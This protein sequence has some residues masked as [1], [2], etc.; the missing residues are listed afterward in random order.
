MGHKIEE[1]YFKNE[2]NF[3]RDTKC[4]NSR[5]PVSATSSYFCHVLG[6]VLQV[7]AA[8]KMYTRRRHRCSYDAK[9][10]REACKSISGKFERATVSIYS[11]I[12]A[13]KH[14][15]CRDLAEGN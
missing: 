1:Q 11:F 7:S 4:E 14:I 5:V 9:S 8:L 2:K 6:Q 15:L 3:S 12:F 13:A 10:R